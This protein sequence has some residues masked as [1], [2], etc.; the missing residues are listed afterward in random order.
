MWEIDIDTGMWVYR[1]DEYVMT[2]SSAWTNSFSGEWI[3]FDSDGTLNVFEPK[4]RCIFD[5][6]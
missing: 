1:H 6:K 2:T 3:S 5:E 4:P